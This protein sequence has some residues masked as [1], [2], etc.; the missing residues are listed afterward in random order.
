M[1]VGWWHGCCRGQLSKNVSESS[2]KGQRRLPDSDR[3]NITSRPWLSRLDAH[4]S[5]QPILPGRAWVEYRHT[6]QH[7]TAQYRV[8]STEYTDKIEKGCPDY[9]LQDEENAQ[10]VECECAVVRREHDLPAF[11]PVQWEPTP[12]KSLTGETVGWWT[13]LPHRERS[14]NR[15][16]YIIQSFLE[17]RE[18]RTETSIQNLHR[19][20]SYSLPA[21]YFSL[22]R[23]LLRRCF[24]FI[25]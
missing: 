5:D 13:P 9:R 22:H 12:R 15:I 21:V 11:N 1:E 6:A 7:S 24:R 16:D 18:W 8:Q 17:E 25:L 14:Y 23:T 20:I 10:L 19:S 2:S 4:A 3:W